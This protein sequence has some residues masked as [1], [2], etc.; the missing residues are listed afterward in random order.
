MEDLITFL[1]IIAAVAFNALRLRNE[2]GRQQGQRPP[3]PS[4]DE[5]PARQPSPL[6]EFFNEIARKF[7]PPP[8][9]MPDWPE[10][11]ERPDNLQELEEYEAAGVPPVPQKPAPAFA[12]SKLPEIEVLPIKGE[13][14][15][16]KTVAKSSAGR[17]KSNTMSSAGLSG[18]LIPTPVLLR[19]AA[20]QTHFRIKNRRQLR[21]SLIASM[22]FGPPRAYEQSFHNTL[23]E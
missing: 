8:H 5:P 9:A 6:E 11:I 7:E 12:E 19:S 18:S 2:K 3:E 15:K 20:G 17:I 14:M 22:V 10:E 13:V 16:P 23:A 1:I 4:G 21:Q